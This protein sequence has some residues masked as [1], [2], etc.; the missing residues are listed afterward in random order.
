MEER[1]R[2]VECSGKG[3]AVTSGEL[4]LSEGGKLIP[5]DNG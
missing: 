3:G 1:V 4:S 2:W 5:R